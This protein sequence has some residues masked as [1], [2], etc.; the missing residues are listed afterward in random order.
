MYVCVALS[1]RFVPEITRYHQTDRGNGW[2]AKLQMPPESECTA[3]RSSSSSTVFEWR[4]KVPFD[5][6]LNVAHCL[7]TNYLNNRKWCCCCRLITDL[8]IWWATTTATTTMMLTIATAETAEAVKIMMMSENSKKDKMA[9]GS[10]PGRLE[11]M[12]MIECWQSK[13]LLNKQKSR[14]SCSFAMSSHLF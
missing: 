8:L 3:V 6:V 11:W 4:F 12:R 9:K 13:I 10:A 14:G 5:F 7:L 2:C 1:H